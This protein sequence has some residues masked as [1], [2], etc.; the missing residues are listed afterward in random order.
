[1]EQMEPHPNVVALLGF[2]TDPDIGNKSFVQ[3]FVHKLKFW[4][5]GWFFVLTNGMKT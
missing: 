4:L 3:T 5:V 1:M 2:C